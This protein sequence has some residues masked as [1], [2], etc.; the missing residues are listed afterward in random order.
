MCNRNVK[1]LLSMKYPWRQTAE[2]DWELEKSIGKL[3]PLSE[4]CEVEEEKHSKGK[5]SLVNV[6]NEL[7]CVVKP[8]PLKIAQ[9]VRE[10]V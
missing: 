2:Y 6:C 3:K 1:Y 8:L 4:L 7:K 5:D 9:Y 10:I